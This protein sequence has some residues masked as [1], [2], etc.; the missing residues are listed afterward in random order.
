MNS[1]QRFGLMRET[2]DGAGSSGRV[3]CHDGRDEPRNVL[4]VAVFDDLEAPFMEARPPA[5]SFW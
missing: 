5:W 1:F 2:K 3:G 4:Q